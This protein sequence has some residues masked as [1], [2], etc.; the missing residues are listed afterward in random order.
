MTIDL[1]GHSEELERLMS[2]RQ[3]VRPNEVIFLEGQ[4]GETAY[5]ILS[6]EVQVSV[7]NKQ[8]NLVTINSMAAG[9]IFGEI[10]LLRDGHERTATAISKD[11]CELLVIEKATFLKHMENADPFLR[12][13]MDHMCKR[14]LMWT[15]R[16]RV[17]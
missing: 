16:V 13:V 10:A 14:V 4:V 11:G 2:K 8:E 17:V 12:L 15:D 6:G 1:P 7:A 9:E 5:I 3:K